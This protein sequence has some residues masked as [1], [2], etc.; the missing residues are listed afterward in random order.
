M[1]KT[2]GFLNK[3]AAKQLNDVYLNLVH[4]ALWGKKQ[5]KLSSSKIKNIREHL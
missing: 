4:K 2:C 5:H 1:L 3:N